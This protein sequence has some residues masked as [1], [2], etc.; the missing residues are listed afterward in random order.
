MPGF[1]PTLPHP[2]RPYRTHSNLR[3]AGCCALRAGVYRLLLD[4]MAALS[5]QSAYAAAQRK[6]YHPHYYALVCSAID[7]ALGAGANEDA[8]A[9]AQA[10]LQDLRDAWAEAERKA[11]DQSPALSAATTMRLQSLKRKRVLRARAAAGDD[12]TGEPTATDLSDAHR[13]A[14]HVLQTTLPGVFRANMVQRRVARRRR[15]WLD[16][17]GIWCTRLNAQ[18]ACAA[19]GQGMVSPAKTRLPVPSRP[20]YWTSA[21]HR[22]TLDADPGGPVVDVTGQVHTERPMDVTHLYECKG[23]LGCVVC[24]V[25][26]ASSGH[27]ITCTRRCQ[28][29]QRI[30]AVLDA[31]SSRSSARRKW[32]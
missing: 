4:D 18:A 6:R 9:W 24:G 19:F 7:I 17:H 23:S 27:D 8:L 31:F 22:G 1:N 25:L 21:V 13:R 30:A 16:Q 28:Q 11:R 5:P 10:A 14:L 20:V 29:Y 12:P 32:R 26:G 15:L 2:T 3:L